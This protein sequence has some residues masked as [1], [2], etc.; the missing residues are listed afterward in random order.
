[1]SNNIVSFEIYIKL[2]NDFIN[3]RQ[4]AEAIKKELI[5]QNSIL[6]TNIEKLKKENNNIFRNK[7]KKQ[8]LTKIHFSLNFNSE[9]NINNNN[10]IKNMN[11][12]LTENY[13]K[14]Q[15]N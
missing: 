13:K 9:N 15:R 11:I 4:E 1:M 7:I 2:K 10:N 12:N 6:Q 3:Y 14:R 8:L 5:E